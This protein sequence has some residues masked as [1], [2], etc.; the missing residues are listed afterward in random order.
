M[1]FCVAPRCSSNLSG[2]LGP[3]NSGCWGQFLF[4]NVRRQ[5]RLLK[6]PFVGFSSLGACSAIAFGPIRNLIT[7]AARSLARSIFAASLNS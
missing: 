2:T 4:D 3:G 5:K 6:P 7:F 1:L